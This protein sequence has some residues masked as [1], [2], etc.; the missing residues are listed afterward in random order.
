MLI[1]GK[2]GKGYETSVGRG[3]NKLAIRLG[4]FSLQLSCFKF[5]YIPTTFQSTQHTK[6][7]F[8]VNMTDY[9]HCFLKIYFT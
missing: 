6:M 9:L 8:K 5:L 4:K 2:T 1:R 7:V 3:E